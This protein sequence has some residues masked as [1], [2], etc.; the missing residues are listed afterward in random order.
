MVRR[1]AKG[2]KGWVTHPPRGKRIPRYLPCKP[3]RCQTAVW[4]ESMTFRGSSYHHWAGFVVQSNRRYG[5]A[6]EQ[7][8]V[9]QND[10][11]TI[12]LRKIAMTA[13]RLEAPIRNEITQRC[14]M[15]RV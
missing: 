10:D 6:S 11:R 14:W 15:R 5:V 1:R 13:I 4:I 7:A 8:L 12:G 9:V 3:P 2:S